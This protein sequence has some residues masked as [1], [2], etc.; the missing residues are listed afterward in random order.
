MK[1]KRL[2]PWAAKFG[3]TERE[4]VVFQG[5]LTHARK[6][7]DMLRE[8]VPEAFLRLRGHT[9]LDPQTH[10]LSAEA[11]QWI[12]TIVADLLDVQRTSAPRRRATPAKAQLKRSL[13]IVRADRVRKKR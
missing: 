4:W 1:N 5:R 6:A 3:F 7:I 11:Q 2:D 9:A 12:S 8:R 10:A 13:H